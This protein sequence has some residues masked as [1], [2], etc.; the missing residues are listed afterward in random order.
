MLDLMQDYSDIVRAAAG[1]I[2]RSVA[3]R[4]GIQ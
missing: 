3:R 4:G 2:T 1:S